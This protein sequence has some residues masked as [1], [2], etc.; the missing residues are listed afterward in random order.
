MIMLRKILPVVATLVLTLY[1]ASAA[2]RIAFLPSFSDFDQQTQMRKTLSAFDARVQAELLIG[3][4]SEVLSRTGLSEVVFEQKLRAAGDAT[5][6]SLRVLPA[7]FLV[8][9]VLDQPKK[10][11]RVSV[12]QVRVGMTFQEPKVFQIKNVNQF[13]DDLA[14]EVANYV[15]NVAGL[16]P[17]SKSAHLR[18]KEGKPLNCSLLEPV[19]SSGVQENLSKISPLIRAVLENVI[20]NDATKATL[21]ERNEA[22]TLLEEK[23]LTAT[24][25]LDANGATDIGR[26]AKADLI[27]I[28]FIHFKNPTQISTDLFAVDVA[29]GRMLASRSWTGGLLDAPSTD[30]VK[31]LLQDGLGAAGESITHPVAD[32]P[33]LR[34]AE[35]IFMIGMKENWAGLR[36]LAATQADLSLRLADASL[37]LAS[38]NPLL[39]KKTFAVFFR[40]STPGAL[41]PLELEYNP[42]DNWLGQIEVLKKSGQLDLI[43]RQAR[44]IFEL[45]MTELAKGN[46]EDEMQDLAD[47]WIRLGDPKKGWAIL[48]RDGQATQRISNNSPNYQIIVI[49]LMNLGR[50]QEC[51]DL[52]ERRGKWNS[53]CTSMILDAYRALGNK[54][55]EF[56]L[57]SINAKS[58]CKSESTTVRFLDLGTEQGKAGES[59]G[60]VIA[61]GNGWTISSPTVRNAMIRARVAAGQKDQAIADAQCGLLSA[62]KTKDLASQKELNDILKSLRASP[63]ASLPIA[64]DF[65]SIPTGCRI[66]LIHDQT[67]DPKYVSEVAALV[68]HF[69]GCAVHI[70]SI[71][72]D[73]SSFSSYQKLSQAL[74]GN[75]FA[76]TIARADLPKDNS[77]G[78][79]LLTQT[80]FISIQKNYS[81]D[82][83]GLYR[84]SLSVISDHYF[85]KF[86]DADP[87][88]LAQITAIASASLAS[89]STILRDH[90]KEQGSWEKVFSPPPPDLFSTNGNLH[91]AA[92]DLGIS[93]ATGA[94]LKKLSI[95]Q[96]VK[97]IPE[98]N[99]NSLKNSPLPSPSD[100]AL[101]LD[102]NQQLA[103][104][105]PIIVTP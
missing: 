36:Q 92:M 47:F 58:T 24:N 30:I 27:L 61:L 101:I 25:G 18:P 10:Q 64:R 21:V 84:G 98:L 70:R 93:P 95:S 55:R 45:P 51:V 29:T 22:A 67:E 103:E 78:T 89:I 66:D 41:Y 17:R 33:D 26:M 105:H 37:A 49:A 62:T 90:S 13:A 38:D 8:L 19:S 52:L 32:D 60:K 71:K 99:R 63:L 72:I 43:Y 12:N 57:M 46:G 81:G 53:L 20:A 76:D 23:T 39:M 6:P 77:L 54:K 102:I 83:Y 79:I 44:R 14:R 68:A 50:Y 85:R 11:L 9:S 73:P 96:V 88:P 48:N 16:T 100:Q 4:N 5:V 40:A 59:I 7:N 87:R 65:I 75:I 31:D 82:V 86:K 42:D 74:N 35:A 94:L 15:A 97:S 80:K 104:A 1:Q 91:L 69:W 28:P 56:E 34:H 2:P 3:W